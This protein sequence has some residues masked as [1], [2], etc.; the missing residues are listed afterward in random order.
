MARDYQMLIAGR[1]VG[2]GTRREVKNKY[3]GSTLG[4]IP[5]ADAAT[6]DHAIA[7]AEQ[8][9]PAMAALPAYQRAG[10]LGKAVA[11]SSSAGR[12]SLGPLQRKRERPSNLHV[13]RP[14]GAFKRSPSPR[15]KPN[16]FM[17]RRCH[18]MPRPPALRIWASI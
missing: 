8:S 16:A 10:I 5:L 3:D 1:W 2:G 7:A 4:T 12:R 15:K 6:I 14:T 13:L 17:A 11:C 18:W 9:F